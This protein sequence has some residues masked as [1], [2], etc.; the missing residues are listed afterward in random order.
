MPAR[1][2]HQTDRANLVSL[3]PFRKTKPLVVPADKIDDL[4]A[5]RQQNARRRISWHLRNFRKFGERKSRCIPDVLVNVDG[6]RT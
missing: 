1:P 6:D 3:K 4:I 5:R 2:G